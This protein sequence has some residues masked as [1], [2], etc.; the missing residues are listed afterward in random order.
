MSF[1]W[2]LLPPGTSLP[3]SSGLPALKPETLEG[4]F[5]E[6]VAPHELSRISAMVRQDRD[7]Q[8]SPV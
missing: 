2:L 3:E 1:W 4:L 5:V 8:D 6:L 7:L